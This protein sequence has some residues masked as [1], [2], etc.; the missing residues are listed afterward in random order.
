GTP[1][2][3]KNAGTGQPRPRSRG[4]ATV[5]RPSAADVPAFP[6]RARYSSNADTLA[7]LA[8]P[9]V[10]ITARTGPAPRRP[11]PD[12]RPPRSSPTPILARPTPG[13]RADPVRRLADS[14]PH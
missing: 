3:S 13:P 9:P 2:G 10:C 6:L 5:Q 11:N 14:L 8:P 1:A 12:P 7:Q 4:P